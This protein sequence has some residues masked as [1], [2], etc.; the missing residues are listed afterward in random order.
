MRGSNTENK[1]PLHIVSAW[2]DESG[3]CFGQKAIKEIE[4]VAIPELL[5]TLQ[6]KG[7][8]VTIDAM[9]TQT[10]IAEKIVKKKADYVLVVKGNQE[11][12]YKDLI[13]YFDDDSFKKQIIDDGNY[14]KTVTFK[15]DSNKTIEETANK[16]MSLIRKWVLSILKLVDMGKKLSLKAKRFS[17]NCR[18]DAYISKIME[19]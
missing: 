2:C 12:L 8:V 9:G 16:N 11:T 4:I 3:I 5:D 14:K 18:P 1:K 15:E 7:Y 19:I 17:I 13:D 6:I 10:K